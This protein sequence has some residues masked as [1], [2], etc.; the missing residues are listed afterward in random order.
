M[1]KSINSL[2]AFST[3]VYIVG[4]SMLTYFYDWKLTVGIFI[5]L[6]AH[7]MEELQKRKNRENANAND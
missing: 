6:W 7:D 1:K 3:I 5:I 4:G 2:T